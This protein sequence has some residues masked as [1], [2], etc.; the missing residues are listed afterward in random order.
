MGG[1]AI[2]VQVSPESDFFTMLVE[3]K[4]YDC[5]TL[6]YWSAFGGPLLGAWIIFVDSCC[7]VFI[8]QVPTVA[9]QCP[10]LVT[11]SNIHIFKKLY[12]ILIIRLSILLILPTQ[13]CLNL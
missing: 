10:G 3:T 7:E 11:A 5:K 13:S 4:I 12:A 9:D 6:L 8:V 1:P 2:R